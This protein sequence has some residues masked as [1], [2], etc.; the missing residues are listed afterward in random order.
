MVFIKLK[1]IFKTR[2][3]MSKIHNLIG[4]C[5]FDNRNL[6]DYI[7]KAPD[8]KEISQKN[9]YLKLFIVYIV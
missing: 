8:P 3:K 2:K 5:G 4:L 9:I 6:I 7:P 1:T